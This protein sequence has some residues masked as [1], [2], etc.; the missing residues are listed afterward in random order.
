[1]DVTKE[2]AQ[3]SLETIR[4]VQAQT[5]RTL[6][7]GGGPLYL[8][9]WGIV[10]FL[11]Y[12]GNHFL[13]P[14]TAGYLW[15]GLSITGFVVSAGVGWRSSTKV[16]SSAN[17]YRIAFFWVA[18]VIY[19]PL[20]VWL[21]GAASDPLAVSIIVSVMAMF[22]YVVMGLWMWTPMVW[23]G[24]GVTAIITLAYL[25]IPQYVDIIMAFLGGGSLAFIGIYIYRNWR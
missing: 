4:Q 17:D 1:M 8:I 20:I 16:R 11:G 13:P 5:R 10:W 9:I 24:A 18:W 12:L 3:I 23:I 22:G 15:M 14:E 6:A 7:H 2:Q 25:T 21:S 19:T